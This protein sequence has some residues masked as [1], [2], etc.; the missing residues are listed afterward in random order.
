MIIHQR[1]R[2]LPRQDQRNVVQSVLCLALLN[3]GQI[4]RRPSSYVVSDKA[5]NNPINRRRQ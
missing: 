4:R 1:I 5:F 3:D 2:N